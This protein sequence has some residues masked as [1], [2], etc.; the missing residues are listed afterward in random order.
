[1]RADLIYVMDQGR[2]IES[3]THR[4]LLLKGGPYATS[5]YKQTQ[6]HPVLE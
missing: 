3:G 5:W 1:M 2:M 6:E 4:E